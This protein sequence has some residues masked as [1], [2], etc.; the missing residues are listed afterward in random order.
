MNE[1]MSIVEFFSWVLRLFTMAK[2]NNEENNDEATSLVGSL[3]AKALEQEFQK[4]GFD[5][6][7]RVYCY[8]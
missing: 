8:L 7:A 2:N 4:T 5:M 1:A 6:T 3:P